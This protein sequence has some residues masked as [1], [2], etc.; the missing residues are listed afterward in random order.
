MTPRLLLSGDSTF[1]ESDL[2]VKLVD[3]R[4]TGVS[5]SQLGTE[6][7]QLLHRILVRQLDSEVQH[8]FPYGSS[9]EMRMRCHRT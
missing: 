7:L 6:I 3:G 5:A 9:P 1:V 8:R 2:T 4:L